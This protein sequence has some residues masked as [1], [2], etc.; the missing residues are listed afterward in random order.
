MKKETFL[1]LIHT[2]TSVDDSY[3]SLFKLGID[4]IDYPLFNEINSAIY[5]VIKDI[6]GAEGLDWVEWWTYEKSSNPE[7]KAF[8]TNENG[9]DIEI[10]TIDDLYDY[11][12]QKYIHKS[13][14]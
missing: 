1:K 4:I 11:L 8:V 2:L 7:L 3:E 13:F 5:D 14:N 12:E 6:Y 10:R 9:E